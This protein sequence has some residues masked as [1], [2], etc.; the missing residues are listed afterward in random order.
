MFVEDMSMGLRAPRKEPPPPPH[1]HCAGLHPIH[2][3][4]NGT[5]RQRKGKFLSFLELKH[6]FFPAATPWSSGFSGFLLPQV[7]ISHFFPVLQQADGLRVGLEASLTAGANSCD[8]SPLIRIS[9]HL[10]GFVFWGTLTNSARK[11]WWVMCCSP[12]PYPEAQNFHLF[13]GRR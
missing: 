10:I 6:S 7:E 11:K 3:G 4:L 13:Y 5:K 8:K 12:A 1:H 2:W 9:I